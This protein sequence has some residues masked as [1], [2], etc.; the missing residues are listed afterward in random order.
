MIER[1]RDPEQVIAVCDNLRALDRT[2][3]LAC[4]FRNDT[5]EIVLNTMHA[6]DLTFIIDNIAV[7]GATRIGPARYQVFMYATDDF[8]K[9]W[10][11][12]TKF[13]IRGIMPELLHR[14]LERAECRSIATHKPAHRWLECLGASFECVA[15]SHGKHGE[16]FYQFGWT[17]ADVIK[18]CGA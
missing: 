16:D 10:M 8:P 6:G 9:I 12:L 17:R 15:R 18:R 1:V 11:A 14:G 7:F 3:L 13:I 4:C 2:E 5:G